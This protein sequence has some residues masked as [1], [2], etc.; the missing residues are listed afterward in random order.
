M[1]D[2]VLMARVKPSIA[3]INDRSKY[4]FFA[5]QD[6]SGKPVWTDE[7]TKIKPLVDW[8]NNTGC[9]TMTYDAPLRKY[10]LV[11]TDGGTT[12]SRYNTYILE[13]DQLTGP[14]KLVVYMH[15]F[16]EQSYFVNI[17]TK[18][19]SADGRTA[20][21]CFAANLTNYEAEPT[22]YRDNPPGSGYGMNLHEI[23]F[24]GEA[25]TH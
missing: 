22:H 7:F 15:H 16:G 5:G 12:G 14:W 3:N 6:E 24:L 20:W 1:G 18:F 8:N 10:L 17:P 21:L 2:Q 13:S 4:E 19:I 25:D 23:K 9:V 11:I